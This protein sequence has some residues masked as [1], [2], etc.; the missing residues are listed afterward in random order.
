MRRS[1]ARFVLAAVALLLCAALFFRG[2]GI[3]KPSG[4]AIAVVPTPP[5]TRETEKPLEGDATAVSG[6]S[7]VQ[8]DDAPART[9]SPPSLPPQPL[10][11][12]RVQD[13]AGHQVAG[14]DV[15]MQ[16]RRAS[17]GWEERIEEPIARTDAAGRF[18]CPRPDA[19]V[20]SCRLL[21]DDARNTTVMPFEFPRAAEADRLI[22]VGPRRDYA[23]QVVDERGAGL[24]GARVSI[25]MSEATERRLLA[26]HVRTESTAWVTVADADGRFS[27]EGVG[28]SEG[29]LLAAESLERETAR[30][31][32]PDASDLGLR[33]VLIAA[34]ARL[35]GT[36]VDAEGRPVEQVTV[37]LDTVH[38]LTDALGRFAFPAPD[39]SREHA[40][41]AVQKDH[42]PARLALA[43]DAPLPDPIVLVLGG[44]PLSI[45]GKVVREDRAPVPG[46]RVW[47]DD[48]VVL[49]LVE[50]TM[51]D[52][53]IVSG[54]DTTAEGLISGRT[55][56]WRHFTSGPDGSFVV[57][58]LLPRAYSLS[59]SDPATL[60]LVTLP[61]VEAGTSG[62]WVTLD[63]PTP[64][65]PVRGRALSMSGV[66]LAGLQVY[67]S[68]TRGDASAPVI[69]PWKMDGPTTDAEGRFAFEALHVEGTSLHFIGTGV[70][71][72]G[73][74]YSLEST[75]DL[76]HLEVRLPAMCSFQVLLQDPKEA[77]RAAVR[78]AQGKL[79]IV[80]TIVGNVGKADVALDL[81]E[82]VSEVTSTSE[83]ARW[84]VL[85]KGDQEVRRVPILLEPVTTA[86][87]RP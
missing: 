35:L 87:L 25:A 37:F 48:A 16:L 52:G 46:A 62:L 82:G 34:E 47:I 24:A 74:P 65:S 78:D 27:F 4:P 64:P 13:I 71:P 22:V 15:R 2:R 70:Y 51:P 42:L 53:T 41:V 54:G 31:L 63:E 86:I 8:S 7:G 6:R 26:G 38:T 9:A 81:A 68:R 57:R 84:L 72:Y 55:G 44:V 30:R 32:L 40:L 1:R 10:L 21:G 83:S 56:P 17:G 73:R 85:L 80:Q 43:K 39:P 61:A 14:A 77:G 75:Q 45:S 23:G 12:G 33:V 69:S 50:R 67:A 5:S 20:R 59:A 19:R 3:E 49:D 66:P 60:A 11:A 36:A 28:W 76:G 79:L 18:E 58:G 29:L